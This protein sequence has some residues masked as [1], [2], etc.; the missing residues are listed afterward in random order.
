M[1]EHH[2]VLIGGLATSEATGALG[3]QVAYFVVPLAAVQLFDA[4]TLEMGVLNLVDSVAALVIGIALGRWIDRV[5]SIRAMSTANAVRCCVL[6][7]LGL[8]FLASPQ[9]WTLYVAMFFMGIA[10]LTH[11]AGLTSAVL[12]LGTLSSHSLNRVNSL[13]RSSS[14][15]SE[16]AGPGVGGLLVATAGFAGGAG[17]G[18]ISFGLASIALLLCVKRAHG[19]SGIRPPAPPRRTS[20]PVDPMSGFRVIWQDRVLR[21]LTV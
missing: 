20:E 19:W 5:G 11:E 13:L 12:R 18:S 14:V 9:M 8:A 17:L 7:L 1:R 16:L 2:R 6:A 4:G 3:V 15:V 10:S 21:R